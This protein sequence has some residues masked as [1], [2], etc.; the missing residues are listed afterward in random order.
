MCGPGQDWAPFLAAADVAVID[1]SSL[2]LYFAL[3]ARPTVA[4]PVPASVVNP[5]A[6]VAVL[7]ALS[8]AVAGPGRLAAA[9]EAS[10]GR[11]DP[12]AFAAFRRGL[13]AHP[14]QAAARTRPVAHE[15]AP[16][17]ARR[18]GSR[19]PRPAPRPCAPR[20]APPALW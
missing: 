19:C 9:I 4:V 14:G 6:P 13:A 18:T 20:T 1:H 17:A 7:R 3:L 15:P 11:F 16:A 8:P 12:A 2:G 5:V 10:A